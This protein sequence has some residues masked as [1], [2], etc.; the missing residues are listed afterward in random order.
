MTSPSSH[1][2]RSLELLRV[3]PGS[4]EWPGLTVALSERVDSRNFEC[5]VGRVA[6]NSVGWLAIQVIPRSVLAGM[7]ACVGHEASVELVGPW[8]DEP[9]RTGAVAH[10]LLEKSLARAASANARRLWTSVGDDEQWRRAWLDTWGFVQVGQ[11]RPKGVNQSVLVRGL[12]RRVAAARI[13]KIDEPFLAD[14][15]IDK[16]VEQFESCELPYERWTH[17][18]HLAVGA[19]YVR[20]WGHDEALTRMRRHIQ[21]YNQSRGDPD[22]YHETLTRLFLQQ[23][24]TVLASSPAD[25]PLHP[26]VSQLAD[27]CTMEWVYQYYSREQLATREAR[28]GW[29][30][31]VRNDSA[32]LFSAD[33]ADKK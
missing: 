32:D 12:R 5:W 9:H 16:L 17:R 31:P 20:R 25:S 1:N 29:I 15:Q 21:L 2:P 3:E 24:E 13:M 6:G 8:I 26:I 23:I 28:R 14:S 11:W 30:S 10:A 27:T 33:G 18:A 7:P 22:G 19:W 4:S